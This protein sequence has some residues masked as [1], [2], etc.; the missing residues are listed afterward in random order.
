MRTERWPGASDLF[1]PVA[2]KLLGQELLRASNDHLLTG[3]EVI[4]DKPACRQRALELHFLTLKGFVAGLQINEHL[5]FMP[6]QGRVRYCYSA[7]WRAGD[8]QVTDDSRSGNQ[9]V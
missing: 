3:F 8:F 7:L 2:L 4:A 5:A 6:D 9:A 1:F